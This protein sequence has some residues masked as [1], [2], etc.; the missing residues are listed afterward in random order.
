M[1]SP[2]IDFRIATDL[3]ERTKDSG[4]S[5]SGTH[6]GSGFE[7]T[8]EL[9]GKLPEALGPERLLSRFDSIAI[10]LQCLLR[11]FGLFLGEQNISIGA[12]RRNCERLVR[13]SN[14]GALV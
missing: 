12:E 14:A 10:V 13:K 5:R 2:S 9:P 7:E 6:V 3:A 4:Q 1:A 11:R 8:P